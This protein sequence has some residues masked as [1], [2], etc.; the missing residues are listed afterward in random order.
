MWLKMPEK[1]SPAAPGQRPRGQT[2]TDVR[3]RWPETTK[4]V[5][6]PVG[7]VPRARHRPGWGI[8]TALGGQRV[9][10]PGRWARGQPGW[11]AQGQTGVAGTGTD[12]PS[13]R[14]TARTSRGQPAP[15]WGPT[16]NVM[17]PYVH[18]HGEPQMCPHSWPSSPASTVGGVQGE[19]PARRG[20]PAVF[21]DGWKDPEPMG[22]MG[23]TTSPA[24]PCRGASHGRGRVSPRT[25]PQVEIRREHQAPGCR[26]TQQQ[27]ASARPSRGGRTQGHA[28]GLSGGQGAGGRPFPSA[29]LGPPPPPPPWP[30]TPKPSAR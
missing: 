14:G 27:E 7:T 16:G 21:H 19:H 3:V 25:S 8:D 23:G 2:G 18:L 30:V 20:D 15:S 24:P 26:A 22:P 29:P 13:V 10:E 17:R 9:W 4:L 12:G 5:P 1:V 28:G 11:Q 6:H